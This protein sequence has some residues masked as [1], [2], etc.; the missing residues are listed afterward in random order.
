MIM[1]SPSEKLCSMCK[2]SFPATPEFFTRDKR[3]K[4]GIS[5]RCKGCQNKL[6]SKWR[7]EN[8][9]YLHNY[10]VENRDAFLEQAKEYRQAHHDE[11]I[12]RGRQYY[13]K[14]QKRI[15]DRANAY[16]HTNKHTPSF[17]AKR[18]A[19]FIRW[20]QSNPDKVSEYNRRQLQRNPLAH[21]IKAHNYR[22]RKLQ[23]SG[24]CTKR[25][26]EQLFRL[27]RGLCWYCGRS[28]Q[29]AYH[30]D[31]RIPLSRGGSNDL[32]NIVLACPHCNQSKNS[33]L[34]SE[35]SDRLL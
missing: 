10:Y 14:N 30:A 20:R 17:R 18:R 34:P 21:R 13:A 25:D 28:I 11:I 3:K 2:E 26:I 31:H 6:T 27:Q 22:A 9:D 33:K 1:A 32:S 23:A 4:S 24:S 8:P 12:L 35:W 7:E 16:Y 15:A 5:S 29:S 19:Q